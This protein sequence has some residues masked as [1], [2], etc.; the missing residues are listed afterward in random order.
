MDF[1]STASECCRHIENRWTQ[2]QVGSV[3]YPRCELEVGMVIDVS[4][5]W[6]VALGFVVVEVR[7]KETDA[8]AV[9]VVVDLS[10]VFAVCAVRAR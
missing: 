8:L 4:H 3:C 2:V 6:V 10:R 1:F 7:E 5:S 9:E